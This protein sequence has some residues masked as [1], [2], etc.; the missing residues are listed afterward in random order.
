MSN[1]I[2]N[3]TSSGLA[4][5]SD[6]DGTGSAHWGGGA[7]PS[8]TAGGDLSGTFPNPAVA[9]IQGT[10]VSATTPT[11]GQSLIIVGGSWT[12]GSITATGTAGGDLLGTYPNPTVSR[13]QGYQIL[14]SV[15]PNVPSVNE[16]LQFD[17]T[18]WKPAGLTAPSIAAAFSQTYAGPTAFTGSGN[19]ITSVS[20]SGFLVYLV[21][22]TAAMTGSAANSGTIGIYVGGGI[23]GEPGWA[24]FAA[25][26]YSSAATSF[27][28]VVG[29]TGTVTFTVEAS[30]PGSGTID[31]AN[32]CISVLGVNPAVNV[33]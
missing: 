21:I 14:A 33:H 9:K 22:A 10:P 13:I 23:I 28:Y 32:L 29:S 15:S 5:L 19:V 27:P 16:V 2:P 17:G 31:I 6:G 26:Q 4:L 12:P 24:S 7:P 18:Y 25:G 11:T 8:G 30:A 3:T 20:V 1:E